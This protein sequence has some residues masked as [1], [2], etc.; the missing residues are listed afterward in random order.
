MPVAPARKDYDFGW[1]CPLRR[2]KAAVFFDEEY[3]PELADDKHTF[4]SCG[5]IGP[6]NVVIVSLD[7]DYGWDSTKSEVLK[8]RQTFKNLQAIL[9][10]GVGGGAPTVENDVRLGDV[11]VSERTKHNQAIVQ[12]NAHT[13]REVSGR[14]YFRPPSQLLLRAAHALNEENQKGT[15]TNALGARLI[16][17]I[18]DIVKRNPNMKSL[19]RP[20]SP[21]QLFESDYHHTD[22]NR[23]CPECQCD[24]TRARDRPRRSTPEFPKIHAGPMASL[25]EVLRDASKRDQVAK[26]KEVLCFEM[27]VGGLRGETEVE[28]LGVRGISDYSDSHKSKGWQDHAAAVA[29]QYSK[30]VLKMVPPLRGQDTATK[31]RPIGAASLKDRFVSKCYLHHHGHL[32]GNYQSRDGSMREIRRKLLR[33]QRT[34]SISKL[35]IRGPGGCGKTQLTIKYCC[36]STS[37]YDYIIWLNADSPQMLEVDLKRA[38]G[39]LCLGDEYIGDLRTILENCGRTWLLVFDNFDNPERFKPTLAEYF[40]SRGSGDIIVTSQRSHGTLSTIVGPAFI[41][42]ERMTEREAYE[43]MFP[44]EAPEPKPKKPQGWLAT[45]KKRVTVGGFMSAIWAPHVADSEYNEPIEPDAGADND[46]GYESDEFVVYD[47]EAENGGVTEKG[48]KLQLLKRLDYHAFS[49]DTTRVLLQ[50]PGW[51]VERFLKSLDDFE[52]TGGPP[53]NQGGHRL[54]EK[55]MTQSTMPKH[56]G[57]KASRPATPI[58]LGKLSL[59]Q[60]H[61]S[62]SGDLTTWATERVLAIVAQIIDYPVDVEWFKLYAEK[63]IRMNEVRDWM[64]PF[65]LYRNNKTFWNENKFLGQL[66]RLAELNLITRINTKSAKKAE[67]TMHPLMRLA[68][69]TKQTEAET[70]DAR[71]NVTCLMWVYLWYYSESR[72]GQ[73]EYVMMEQATLNT[74]LGLPG[75]TKQ[76][77]M[78]LKNAATLG[79]KAGEMSSL[80]RKYKFSKTARKIMYY[81]YRWVLLL[82]PFHFGFGEVMKFY[83]R[84][85][86]DWIR[87]R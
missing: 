8:L 29:A 2:E 67:F 72:G 71:F 10:V 17:Q 69:R 55:P 34:N 25:D 11:V 82:M 30:E 38:I 23:S 74:M 77:V 32:L 51:T 18:N 57:Q 42:A 85:L 7:D 4:Y 14:S 46:S 12:L 52:H 86:W 53:L 83:W 35:S 37:K 45:L 50:Q 20:A 54:Y 40:P 62:G 56:S 63:C 21:D 22:R 68:V 5:K 66:T 59:E 58:H 81:K 60:L 64:Q 75:D 70:T 24:E 16:S 6:H 28:W 61:K 1:L 44:S 43:L 76:A 13:L 48:R 41:E 3:P 49:V 26:Q 73:A 87:G 9:L 15:E 39:Q 80:A 84:L 65:L 78:S 36:E 19:Q 27:E 31:P 47:G 79:T 33:Q